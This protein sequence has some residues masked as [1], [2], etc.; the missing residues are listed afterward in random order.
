[1]A[2][3]DLIFRTGIEGVDDVNKQ[4]EQMADTAAKSFKQIDES[5]AKAG[6]ADHFAKLA[7]HAQSA[8]A[9]IGSALDGAGTHLDQITGALAKVSDAAGKFGE[10]GLKL[11]GALSKITDAAGPLKEGIDAAGG[12]FGSVHQAVTGL[13]ACSAASR[14]I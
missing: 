3:N 9:R 8:F 2:N 5:A 6:D 12:A 14:P 4:V 13:P 7:D 11:A 10:P 1:M